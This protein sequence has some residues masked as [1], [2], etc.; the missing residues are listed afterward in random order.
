MRALLALLLL[1]G[2]SHADKLTA[3]EAAT[4]TIV[5]LQA[6]L[7]KA[8]ADLNSCQLQRKYSLAKDDKIDPETLEIT[9]APKPVPA[10]PAKAVRK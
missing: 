8:L 6:Q 7:A 9:R 2:V 10:T 5:Q 3:E 1:V 4:N